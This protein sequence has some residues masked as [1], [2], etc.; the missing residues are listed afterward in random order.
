MPA[1]HIAELDERMDNLKEMH[2]LTD[3]Q[4]AILAAFDDDP[5]STYGEISDRALELLPQDATLSTEYTRAVVTNNRPSYF[6]EDGRVK[7][8]DLSEDEEVD[9]RASVLQGWY[10][11]NEAR[12]YSLAPSRT[13][14]RY[15]PHWSGGPGVGRASKSS[16]RAP[17]GSRGGRRARAGSN[18]V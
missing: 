11:V 2:D 6:N 4:A 1:T 9:A 12:A 13:R 8:Q 7:P 18:Q 16:R 10:G 5:G 15:H 17:D 3:K 14:G